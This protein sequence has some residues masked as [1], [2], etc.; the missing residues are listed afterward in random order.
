MIQTV[1]GDTAAGSCQ[2]LNVTNVDIDAEL[3]F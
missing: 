3:W 1:R 2:Q